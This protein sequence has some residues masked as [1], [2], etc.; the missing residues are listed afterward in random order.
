MPLESVAL[1]KRAAKTKSV[2][3][4][5]VFRALRELEKA[6]LQDPTWPAIVGGDRS[7]GHRWGSL[8]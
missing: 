6:S 5:E 4:S 3:S 2:K 8:P 7:P 1:L